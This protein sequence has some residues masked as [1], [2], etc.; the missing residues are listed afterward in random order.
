[1]S[2]KSDSPPAKN[3][4]HEDEPMESPPTKEPRRKSRTVPALTTAIQPALLKAKASMFLSHLI[5]HLTKYCTTA[6]LPGIKALGTRYSGKH[7]GSKLGDVLEDLLKE[8]PQYR[9]LLV[10]EDE[11]NTILD[12]HVDNL[13]R[14]VPDLESL[15]Q[16]TLQFRSL[17]ISSDQS[18]AVDINLTIPATREF[19][20]KV[21][22]GV[23]EEFVDDVEGSWLHARPQEVRSIVAASIKQTIDS[24]LPYVKKQL[25][26]IAAINGEAADAEVVEDVIEEKE[27]EETDDPDP[28]ESEKKDKKK[29][30]RISRQA[31][32]RKNPSPPSSSKDGSGSDAGSD[33]FGS[34][35][36]DF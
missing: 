27:H 31:M 7:K 11:G 24:Y 19:V 33:Q 18:S 13:L 9:N 1:M 25:D 3:K 26:A 30:I 20:D 17:L 36:D 32:K 16:H 14:R 15:I 22:A 23:A 10:P 12:E 2:H 28:E 5:D 21:L 34:D 35:E 8:V 6:F 4:K 29:T